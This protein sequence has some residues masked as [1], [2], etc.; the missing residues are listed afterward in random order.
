ML[1]GLIQEN[2]GQGEDQN[3]QTGKY[4]YGKGWQFLHFLAHTRNRY[5]EL[6][7]VLGNRST[8]NGIPFIF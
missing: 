5:I 4:G 2:K 8:G 7:A 1:D 3:R 6:F